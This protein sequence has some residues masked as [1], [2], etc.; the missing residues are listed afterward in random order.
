MR[1]LL[2]L[3]IFLAGCSEDTTAPLPPLIGL[4]AE[5]VVRNL[6]RPILVG[7]TRGDH[8]RLF[9]AELGGRIRMLR[10]GVLQPEPFLDISSIVS[11]P[12]L[13]GRGLVGFAIHPL[14]GR[15]FVSYTTGGNETGTTSWIVSYRRADP[16]HVDPASATVVM[17]FEQPLGDHNGG[18]ILF[19]PDRMLYVS[20]GDGGSGAARGAAQQLW[21]VL[22][23]ILRVDVDRVPFAI[24]SDNPFVGDVL[25][26][27]EIWSYG[28]RHPWRISFDRR[29]GDLYIADVG[30]SRR[31][32][33]HVQP[34]S[35]RGGENWGWPVM[36]GS[37][38]FEAGTCD[39]AGYQLPVYEYD[40]TEGCSIT[41]GHVYRGRLIPEIE[42]LYFFADFC[43]GWIRSL[44][45]SNGEVTDIR[46]WTGQLNPDGESIITFGEDGAGEL[47]F[48]TLD[49]NVYRIVPVRDAAPPPA[50]RYGSRSLP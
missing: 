29:T 47:Y 32:E 4:G 11:A 38:C 7:G 33:L 18:H 6:D 34:A 17:R 27:P 48:A 28:L 50:S 25:V 2:L 20:L 22:G 30:E 39:V 10:D 3:L 8:S 31:E 15:L 9:I 40:H 36:E 1:R 49:G 46:D 41:G 26:R 19:G 44:R 23:A 12:D 14:D 35:S 42:G 37:L 16:D 45:W 13:Q 21:N 24:P 43:R 5:P